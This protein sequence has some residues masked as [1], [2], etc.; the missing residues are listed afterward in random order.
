M[1]YFRVYSYQTLYGYMFRKKIVSFL[2]FT[3][4]CFFVI[5]ESLLNTVFYILLLYTPE[6]EARVPIKNRFF[7]NIYFNHV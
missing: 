4:R 2:L 6:K 1:I 7:S 3:S 5:F